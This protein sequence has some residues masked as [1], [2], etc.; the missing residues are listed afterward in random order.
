MES[1][2][3][4]SEEAA[5]KSAVSLE[6]IDASRLADF[7]RCPKLFD[8]KHNYGYQAKGDKID[9]I[10]GQLLG[11]GLELFEKRLLSG[12]S[13][14]FAH[15]QA[16]QHVLAGSTN[17][18]GSNRF[19]TFLDTWRCKGE[20]PYKN[21]KGNAAKCPY[22]HKG[23][24]YPSPAPDFCSC[25]S[26]IELHELWMPVKAGK[27][28]DRLVQLLV[29]YTDAAH[30]RK[31]I[32]ESLNGVP[33]IEYYWE[34]PFDHELL[35]Q[36]VIL[37][38]NWDAVKSFKPETFVVDYKSTGKGLT[39]AYW[40]QFTPNIQVDLYN[41][42][43]KKVLPQ[44]DIKGVAIEAFSTTG[45][46]GFRLFRA[47]D[48]Q[49]AETFLDT[50]FWIGL[51]QNCRLQNLWPRNRTSCF[52]CPFQSVCS[53]PP[54]ARQG[55]L[56]TQFERAMWNPQTRKLEPVEPC[57]KTPQAPSELQNP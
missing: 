27:D 39:D 22:S 54:E 30:T 20:K 31:L 47:T 25:G 53:R 10:F 13:I 51:L 52:L 46:T 33:L 35:L 32:P 43:A 16:L 28:I 45:E 15:K 38:G 57:D 1:S 26:D 23:K 21:E 17:P 5:E 40:K 3:K 19:G 18:D 9:L 14:D 29:G 56:D 42:A 34:A 36:P 11:E 6:H 44:F 8:Y 24:Y 12:D 7:Q 49:K 41:M 2:A 37:C 48:A 55:I 50:A 4:V